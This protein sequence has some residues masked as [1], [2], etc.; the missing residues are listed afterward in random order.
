MDSELACRTDYPFN[1]LIEITV[2]PARPVSFPLWFRVP[3][4][5]KNPRLTVNG[6]AV[7]AV[8]GTNGFVCLRRQWQPNDR[9]RLLFPMSP[10]V[11]VGRDSNADGAPYATVNYGPL[12]FALPVA[13]TTDPNRADPAARWNYALET[14]GERL[15]ADLTV[16][17]GP[18][19]PRWNW[20]LASPLKLHAQA[21][22]IDWDGKALP[23]KAIAQGQTLPERLT[24]VPYGCTKFR[25]AMM[26]VTARAFAAARS[27]SG[28]RD[29]R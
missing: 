21:V 3:G 22:R 25:V 13:D 1:E 27:T 18:M 10:R 17:R 20:P 11:A 8:P 14:T 28:G 4:W 19:P 5:C 16:E 23:A 12:L 26:P 9:L 2:R 24:L 6:S 15:D 7:R 29:V